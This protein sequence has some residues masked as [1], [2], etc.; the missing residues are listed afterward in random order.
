MGWAL[1]I[2][3][4]SFHSNYALLKREQ[5][6]GSLGPWILTI[7]G[8]AFFKENNR[9]SIDYTEWNKEERGC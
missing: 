9:E 8:E 2:S 6:E 3:S 4:S 1:G 5:R 7:Q